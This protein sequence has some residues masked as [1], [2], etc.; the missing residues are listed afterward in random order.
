MAIHTI[1]DEKTW[2]EYFIMKIELFYNKIKNTVQEYVLTD[3]VSGSACHAL[4]SF[5]DEIIN[6][7][8][9]DSILKMTQLTILFE[10]FYHSLADKYD[11]KK[12]LRKIRL[13][14]WALHYGTPTITFLL[15]YNIEI[16]ET[17]TLFSLSKRIMNKPWLIIPKENLVIDQQNEVMVDERAIF[18]VATPSEEEKLGGFLKTYN[19]QGGFTTVPCDF[20]SQQFIEYAGIIS[21]NAGKVLEIAAAFGAASLRAAAQGANVFCNDI[22]PRNLAVVRNRYL[23]KMGGK[24]D[25]V[26]GDDPKLVLVPGKFPEELD[27]LPKNFFDAILICRVLH[28]FTGEQIE[29]SLTQLFTSLKPGGKLYIVCETPF[30][31][32]WKR[33]IPEYEKRVTEGIKWPGEITSPANYESSGRVT[34]LPKFVH[35]I[36]REILEVSLTTAQ[37]EIEH[38]S[39]INRSGQFPDDL[40]LDG[41][42]SV[43]AVAFKPC[44][45]I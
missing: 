26:T 22:E 25:V 24:Q 20:Y 15:T 30:L 32:N 27:G 9:L 18:A 6:D 39:Y 3:P 37:F 36:T 33:F 7:K 35:W 31:K 10:G 28:F 43:G 4:S 13:T 2:N 1:P 40:L 42:E 38:I 44:E 16:E 23:E 5:L 8:H 41:R 12:S 29:K 19:P 14:R 34:S 21:K 45:L 11:L 17:S